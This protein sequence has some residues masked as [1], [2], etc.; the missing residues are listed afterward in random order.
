MAE[1]ARRIVAEVEQMKEAA[2]RNRDPEAGT[3]RLGM[4][5]TLGPYL[6]SPIIA[7]AAMALSSVSVITNAARLRRVK[8]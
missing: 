2:R 6:L 5:P 7:A 4:F 3:V 8:L 1:R